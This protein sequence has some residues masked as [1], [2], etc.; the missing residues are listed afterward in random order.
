M[1]ARPGRSDRRRWRGSV[2][3]HFIHD[4]FP[5]LAGD[6][7]AD[8]IDR[9]VIGEKLEIAIFR[10]VPA[11]DDVANAEPLVAER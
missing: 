8:D 4:Q 1:N 7:V 3:G 10:C 6:I 9:T 5:V 2:I 11:V